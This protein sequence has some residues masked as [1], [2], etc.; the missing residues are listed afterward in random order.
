MEVLRLKRRVEELGDEHA[1]MVEERTKM[2]GDDAERRV[3]KAQAKYSE[4]KENVTRLD[5][6][7]DVLNQQRKA[8]KQKLR[9]K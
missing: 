6:K 1:K 7:R 5:G 3:K 4:H 2:G 8:L 9:Q